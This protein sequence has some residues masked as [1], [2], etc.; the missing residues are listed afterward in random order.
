MNFNYFLIFDGQKRR[1]IGQVIGECI[2]FCQTFYH[3]ESKVEDS[4]SC[5][6]L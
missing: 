2:M 3:K 1:E 4:I 5:R 6:T